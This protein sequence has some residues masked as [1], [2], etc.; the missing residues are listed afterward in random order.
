M[1]RILL[2]RLVFTTL[3]SLCVSGPRLGCTDE[4]SDEAGGTGM[5]M[6]MG[7]EMEMAMASPAWWWSRC[8]TRLAEVEPS[9]RA[10]SSRHDAWP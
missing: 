2:S 1:Q 3:L 4:A 10:P 6:E 5:A 9:C 7:T 8:P